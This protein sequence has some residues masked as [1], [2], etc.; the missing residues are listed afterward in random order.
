MLRKG[1]TSGESGGGLENQV[2]GKQVRGYPMRFA[3]TEALFM[4]WP[5]GM[6]NNFL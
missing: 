2:I 3:I 6:Y 4:E 1:K 5:D